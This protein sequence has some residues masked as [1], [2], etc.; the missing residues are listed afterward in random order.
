MYYEAM[1]RN[2]HNVCMNCS[3]ISYMQSIQ[4]SVLSDM[5]TCSLFVGGGVVGEPLSAVYNGTI[6]FPD[7]PITLGQITD[8]Q[9]NVVSKLM[10]YG[11]S[12]I[13]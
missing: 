9:E 1:I 2:V 11:N 7:L 6:F 10:L 8:T 12:K 13:P 4:C 5:L 3:Y